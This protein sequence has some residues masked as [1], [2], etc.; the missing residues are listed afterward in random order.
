MESDLSSYLKFEKK[1]PTTKCYL[2]LALLY[3]HWNAWPTILPSYHFWKVDNLRMLCWG[4]KKGSSKFN[5]VF[6]LK[7]NKKISLSSFFFL[8]LVDILSLLFF[9]PNCFKNHDL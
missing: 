9:R 1:A 6:F 4:Y 8:F 7:K 2:R 5:A 3:C